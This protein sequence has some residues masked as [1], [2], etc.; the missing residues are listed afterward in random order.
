MYVF[1]LSASPPSFCFPFFQYTHLCSYDFSPFCLC[2]TI[3]S[4][5]RIPVGSL[6]LETLLY[7]DYKTYILLI[8]SLEN[9]TVPYLE[10]MVSHSTLYHEQRGS[11]FNGTAFRPQQIITSPKRPCGTFNLQ[12]HAPSLQYTVVLLWVS[13]YNLWRNSEFFWSTLRDREQAMHHIVK[14][15]I[16]L[17]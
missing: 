11:K 1:R 15:T 8:H 12:V 2:L 9:I 7:S 17:R 16:V 5:H 10:V 13:I 3:S 14:R 6:N 4:R